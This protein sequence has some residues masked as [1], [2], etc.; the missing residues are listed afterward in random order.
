MSH[1]MVELL[2]GELQVNTTGPNVCF[3]VKLPQLTPDTLQIK[4]SDIDPIHS[5]HLK[6]NSELDLKETELEFNI[7]RQTL[8]LIEP[9]TE[10]LWSLIDTFHEDF[11]IIP[12]RDYTQTLEEL[13]AF[14]PDLIIYDITGNIAEGIEFTEQVKNNK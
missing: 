13:K 14:Q 10:L 3:I 6:M 11:N 12:I 4:F 5:A 7:V 8:F 9:N 2:Q 1:N